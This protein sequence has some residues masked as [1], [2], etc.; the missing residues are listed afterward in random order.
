MIR[1]L[2]K[3]LIYICPKKA[4]ETFPFVKKMMVIFKGWF[5]YAKCAT[6]IVSVTRYTSSIASSI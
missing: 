4:E 2:K 3:L 5:S 1:T 6:A